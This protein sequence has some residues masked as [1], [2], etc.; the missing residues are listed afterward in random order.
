MKRKIDLSADRFSLH[1]A[2]QEGNLELVEV[3]LKRVLILMKLI[4][5]ML[6]LSTLMDES[7]KRPYI[8][9]NLHKEIPPNFI[10]QSAL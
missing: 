2:A 9:I 6:H 5:T 4:R 8:D 1:A 3:L 7:I 10:P